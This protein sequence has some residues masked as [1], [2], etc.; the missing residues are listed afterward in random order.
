MTANR[1][2]GVCLL[3]LG[4]GMFVLGVSMFSYRGNVSPIVS[5]MGMY[6]FFL[7][8]PTLITGVVMIFIRPF[9]K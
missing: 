9:K 3:L 1:K 4:V 8:L 5:K 2:I 6:S 7:W